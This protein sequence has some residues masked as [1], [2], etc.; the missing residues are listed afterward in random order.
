[1]VTEAARAIN[2]DGSIRL[3]LPPL[4]ALLGTG[5]AVGE[6]LVR[7]AI[8]ANLKVGD[9]AS[10]ARLAAFAKNA[11]HPEALRVEAIAALGVWA[12]PSPLDRVDGYHLDPAVQGGNRDVGAARDA[13][14]PLLT[15]S[16]AAGPDVKVAL[17]EAA[18]RLQLAEAEPV[19][20]GQLRSDPSAD[21][22]VASLEAL[23]AIGGGSMA[24]AMKVAVA[25]TD[26]EVRRAALA[27]LPTLNMSAAAKADNLATVI[28][29]GT[30]EDKQAG[31]EVLGTL[32]SLEA[33]QV[34]GSFLDELEKGTVPVAA[35]LDLV[36]AVQASGA[37]ALTSRLEA[38][39]KA[40]GADS[41]LTAFRPA[42]LAGGNPN[43]G[44][45]LFLEQPA[46]QC[47]RC[48]SLRGGGSDVGPTLNQVGVRLS[49]EQILQS[50]LEPSA[51]VAPGYGIVTLTLK[52]GDKV[53][54]MLKRD[55][56]TAVVLSVGDPP[57]ERTIARSE[58]VSRTDPISAMPP[59]GA[60]LKPREIRDIVAFLGTLKY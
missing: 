31:L 53:S 7:R 25:D 60:I 33:Q 29:N 41:L 5:K 8:S 16:A 27:L 32:K 4:A 1:V 56:E 30:V 13:L 45:T 28:R 3:G 10:V 11:D 26:P 24:E 42:L 2:D 47:S 58:I 14:L 40:R 21:V 37:P 39:Q 9:T 48:H 57:V 50:L 6:P 49:S 15:A 51:V 12:A 43:A 36:D 38:Y 20:M 19:L 18:G 22:R 52:S 44:R 55:T 23:Q 34:L 35:Q 17:A 46:A 54:G 59:M